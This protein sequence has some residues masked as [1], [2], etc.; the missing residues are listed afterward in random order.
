MGK[1]LRFVGS[2]V[3]LCLVWLAPVF[4]DPPPPPPG[5][6]R[7][8]RPGGQPPGREGGP[9]NNRQQVEAT[10]LYLADG[11]AES[12]PAP[13]TPYNATKSNQSAILARNGAKVTVEE[14]SI[15]KTG[16]TTSR[17]QSNFA[18]LNAAI[19]AEKGSTIE[20]AGGTIATAADGANVL[21]A[22]GSGAVVTAS[23]TKIETEGNSS[24]GLDAT[25]GGTVRGT[26]LTIVTNGQHCAALATDRGG[27]KVQVKEVTATTHGAGSPGIY[28]T[29]D[30]QAEA[31]TFTAT[32][33]EA[34]VIEGRNSIT[35]TDCT[36]KG[37]RKCGAMLYQ[38]FSGD[39][40]PG[41]SRYTMVGGSLE[42]VQGPLF[43]VTNTTC[44]VR[45][46]KADLVAASGEL[47]KACV[48]RW[49]RSGQ[50]GGHAT[51][52]AEEQVL[53]GTVSADAASSLSLKL[54][55]GTTWTGAVDAASAGNVAVDVGAKWVLTA[56]SHVAS[57]SFDGVSR[58]EG[59]SRIDLQGHRLT[60][61]R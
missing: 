36:M 51:L 29:G 22:T 28:S 54:G 53:A 40:E 48:D 9:G 14:P 35:V 21:F 57:L 34:A 49:G 43:C 33:S 17:D 18:G 44:E 39:A 23:G 12:G 32:G 59:E 47:L 3:G 1:W 26:N 50:N 52:R 5:G 61:G 20:V 4:A 55:K 10:A 31:S 24:R 15:R 11:V 8:G 13:T 38:S 25:L 56:D 27:G 46:T 30:I 42:A 16:D 41:I 37:M 45:L 19:C 60:V 58:Q 7:G 2:A 6:F